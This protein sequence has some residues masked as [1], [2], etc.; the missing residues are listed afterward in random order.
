M[1]K[2]GSCRDE[3]ARCWTLKR[4]MNGLRES[5]S[6]AGLTGLTGRLMGLSDLRGLDDPRL[7]G[8]MPSGET[9][10][11]P[12]PPPGNWP[13][14]QRPAHD[15]TST[16]RSGHPDQRGRP[17][18]SGWFG[19]YFPGRARY[20]GGHR[21][22]RAA[23]AG[24]GPTGYSLSRRARCPAQLPEP[25]PGRRARIERVCAPVAQPVAPGSRHN[26]SIWSA[27]RQIADDGTRI[28]ALVAFAGRKVHPWMSDY[29][30]Y[31]PS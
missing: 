29:W 6:T 10:W 11:P 4:R 12:P 28:E 5:A 13:T 24:T 22:R 19:G 18:F 7:Y 31:S 25:G 23:G 1:A 21:R 26:V 30:G 15:D 14:H 16:G 2:C 17:A 3:V 20:C 9:L 8:D 27:L